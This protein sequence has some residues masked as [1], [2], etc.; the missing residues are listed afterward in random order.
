M[1]E[2]L[3]T[4]RKSSGELKNQVVY[5][6]IFIALLIVFGI[7]RNACNSSREDLIEALLWENGLRT[8]NVA[9]KTEILTITRERFMVLFAQEKLGFRRPKEDEVYVL[10]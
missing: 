7:I 2:F 4:K 1:K 8:E 6:I 9:L 10:K 5:F 3:R